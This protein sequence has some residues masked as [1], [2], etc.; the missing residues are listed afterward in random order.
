[1]AT[2]RKL[3]RDLAPQWTNLHQGSGFSFSR[4]WLNFE[5]NN[6][7]ARYKPMSPE[8]VRWNFT[9]CSYQFIIHAMDCE[10]VKNFVIDRELTHSQSET[11]CA[12]A[13][14]KAIQYLNHHNEAVSCYSNGYWIEKLIRFV[15]IRQ[16]R[17]AD[18]KWND[19]TTMRPKWKRIILPEQQK[20]TVTDKNNKD[21]KSRQIFVF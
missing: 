10:F 1:M 3:L 18:R 9:V 5:W 16:A 7:H 13:A 19:S 8:T 11:K 21:S 2:I 6:W 17:G 15:C 14:S 12:Q 20:K 4:I